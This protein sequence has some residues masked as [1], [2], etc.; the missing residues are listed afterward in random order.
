MYREGCAY[1]LKKFHDEKVPVLIFS[2]GI[3]G[4]A[5]YTSTLMCF[6]HN[7]IIVRITIQ[8]L[9]CISHFYHVVHVGTNWQGCQQYLLSFI[10]YAADVVQEVIYQQAYLYDNI[11]I[12]SNFIDWNEEVYIIFTYSN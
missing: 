12:V 5:A 6:S 4:E 7:K 11:S 3:G 1:V 9:Y 10:Y 8:L 2:A